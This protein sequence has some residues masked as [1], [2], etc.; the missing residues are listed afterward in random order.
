MLA[1]APSGRE[2]LAQVVPI[3]SMGRGKQGPGRMA[4]EY[5]R[6]RIIV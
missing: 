1:E 6:E 2:K 3:V 5:F 4:H